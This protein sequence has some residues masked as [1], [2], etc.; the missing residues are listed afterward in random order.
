MVSRIAALLLS[1][2]ALLQVHA[3]TVP[4]TDLIGTWSSKSNAT[5]TGEVCARIS[6]TEIVRG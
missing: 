1:G 3:Q 5:L 6:R 2:V 4:A